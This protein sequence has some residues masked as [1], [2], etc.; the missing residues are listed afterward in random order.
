MVASLYRPDD[1]EQP[2]KVN[3]TTGPQGLSFRSVA[4]YRVTCDILACRDTLLQPSLP[5][6]DVWWPIGVESP[7]EMALLYA[8]ADCL[9]TSR[10]LAFS[11]LID[12]LVEVVS[13]LREYDFKM[14]VDRLELE[15]PERESF[16]GLSRISG[17]VVSN[18]ATARCQAASSS[19]NDADDRRRVAGPTRGGRDQ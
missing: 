3:L 19:Q 18:S 2:R 1:S 5:V 13:S 15:S 4:A 14:V 8:S 12:R 10:R 7:P 11:L 17:I 9:E 6:L 16:V